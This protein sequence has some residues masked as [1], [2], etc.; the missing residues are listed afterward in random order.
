MTGL[1]RIISA[2]IMRS[3]LREKANLVCTRLEGVIHMDRQNLLA[4]NAALVAQVV[5]M[6]AEVSR[7]VATAVEVRKL[8]G[9]LE[10]RHT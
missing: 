10:R 3:M 5:E 4:S 1:P 7:L 9:L 8:P 2:A 6:A